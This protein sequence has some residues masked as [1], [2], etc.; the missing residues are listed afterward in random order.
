MRVHEI[1][2]VLHPATPAAAITLEIILVLTVGAAAI[3]IGVMVLLARAL[4]R[5]R[6]RRVA[7][8]WVWVVGGGVAFPIAVLSALLAY[9]MVRS[10]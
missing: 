8:V 2:S 7:N 6:E 1:A 3:F 10:L 5:R 4:A 9:S